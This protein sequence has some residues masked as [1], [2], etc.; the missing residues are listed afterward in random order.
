MTIEHGTW[1]LQLS[2]T[3]FGGAAVM[4]GSST[5]LARDCFTLDTQQNTDEWLEME[6]KYTSQVL[7]HPS[8]RGN[9]SCHLMKPK[10]YGPRFSR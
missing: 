7:H 8:E 4:I 3:Y 9:P 5:L 10:F 6:S 2:G 1:Q